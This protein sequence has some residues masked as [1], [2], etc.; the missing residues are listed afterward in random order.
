MLRWEYRVARL[1]Q[2]EDLQELHAL[3]EPGWRL[4]GTGA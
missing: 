3:G 4:G 2:S 1:S